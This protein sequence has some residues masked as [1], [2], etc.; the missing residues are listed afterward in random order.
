MPQRSLGTVAVCLLSVLLPSTISHSAFAEEPD[1][2]WPRV[3]VV[4]RQI[5]GLPKL[6]ARAGDWK[7][8]PCVF[9]CVTRLDPALD[10][11]I[12]GD[13]VVDSDVFRLPQGEGRVRVDVKPG[14]TMLQG[15]GTFLAI[16]GF[17]FMAGGGAVLLVP[18]AEN[19]TEKERTAKTVVGIGTL[20][21]GVIAAAVGILVRVL[22][23][24]S[25]TVTPAS[26]AR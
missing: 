25:V 14:S 13:G 22:S 8:V 17:A 26:E 3:E 5:V 24:T 12:S 11:R 1:G 16:G 15:M 18:S 2:H 20:S 7:E 19:A 21:M 23:D 6:E 4:P 10:Y 9:P